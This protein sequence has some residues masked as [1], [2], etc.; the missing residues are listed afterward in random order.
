MAMKKT[1]SEGNPIVTMDAV[2]KAGFTNL[3]DYLNDKR[4]LK[5][6]DGKAVKRTEEFM[7]NKKAAAP[8][9]DITAPMQG[10][11]VKANP[12]ADQKDTYDRVMRGE[13]RKRDAAP[14]SR[15]NVER[16]TGN[17]MRKIIEEQAEKE[18]M[19]TYPKGSGMKKGGS[20]RG[21]GIAIKGKTK[22][23]MV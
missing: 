16:E 1:D 17:K 18:R 14:P 12:A 19:S 22:G 8:S 10:P 6:R 21:D 3:R 23:R 20:V 4:G 15:G 9:K 5:R 13:T 7:A 11:A 2:K